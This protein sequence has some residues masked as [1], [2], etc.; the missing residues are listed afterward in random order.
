MMTLSRVMQTHE[1]TDKGDSQKKLVNR[2]NILTPQCPPGFRSE[3]NKIRFL[4]S[5]V[6]DRAWDQTPVSNIIT[7]KYTFN[8]FVTVLREQLQL[9]A[10]KKIRGSEAK[11][12][13]YTRYARNPGRR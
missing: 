4:R 10:E 8:S 12:T 13:Y 3:S 7:A 9:Q 1:I 2:I 5:A 11:P 6:L